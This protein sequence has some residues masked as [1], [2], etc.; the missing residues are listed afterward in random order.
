[1]LLLSTA[2]HAKVS[3]DGKKD[4]FAIQKDSSRVFKVIGEINAE[5]L[6][7]PT[8][9]LAKLSLSNNPGVVDMIIDSPGGRVDAGFQFIILMKQFQRAGGIIRCSVVS[10]AASMAYHIFLHCNER[11][12]LEESLLLWHRARVNVG[13][14]M[15]TPMTYNEASALAVQLKQLDDHIFLDISRAMS[16]ASDKFLRYHFERET[17]HVASVL[18]LS[19]PGFMIVH[20]SI[21][22]LLE[23]ILGKESVP[24]QNSNNKVKTP[25]APSKN[26]RPV[27]TYQTSKKR[28]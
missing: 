7:E 1:M 23:S 4:E 14:F 6:K 10:M 25:A 15:G 5:S 16:G 3:N 13:G 12:A 11:H 26:E 28:N 19:V 17:M 18:S 8:L 22:N 20:E 27:F 9:T 21:G 2:S 24:A